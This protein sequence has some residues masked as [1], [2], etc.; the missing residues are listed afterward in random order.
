VKSSDSDAQE[1]LPTAD[2]FAASDFPLAIF[3]TTGFKYL[4][5][6][7]IGIGSYIAEGTLTIR[8]KP[9]KITL[10]FSAKF[11]EDNDTS[12]PTRYALIIG[13]TTLKRTDFGIGQGDWAK[14]DAVADEVKIAIHI[15]ARQ[16]K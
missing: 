14:T 5:S 8:G 7:K 12:P 2:W 9:I 15:E 4:G 11:Y 1:N 3:E 10:P 6:D 13:T 16:V